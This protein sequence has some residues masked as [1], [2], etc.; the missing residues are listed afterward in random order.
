MGVRDGR[1]SP[2][3]G[4]GVDWLA[5]KH[6]LWPQPYPRGAGEGGGRSYSP[7]VDASGARALLP[8]NRQAGAPAC[9]PRG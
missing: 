3:S 2:I 5:G 8:L 9:R 4:A 1:K 6:V 7:C